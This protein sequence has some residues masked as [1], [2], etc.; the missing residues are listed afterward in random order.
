MEVVVILWHEVIFGNAGHIFIQNTQKRKNLV[1]KL[2]VVLDH[3]L[4]QYPFIG[5]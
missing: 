4:T 1:I 3:N 2:V 5:E